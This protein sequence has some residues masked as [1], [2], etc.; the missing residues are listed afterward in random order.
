MRLCNCCRNVYVVFV[1]FTLGQNFVTCDI[2]AVET[3]MR[4]CVHVCIHVF[5]FMSLCMCMCTRLSVKTLWKCVN[6]CVHTYIHTYI[7]TY[8]RGLQ[9]VTGIK[10]F[11]KDP[12]E[13]AAA[14]EKP[15]SN[16]NYQVCACSHYVAT[17]GCVY[18][19]ICAH[20]C[21]T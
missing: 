7:H 11:S 19:Y 10:I 9:R 21:A 2:Q 4:R 13:L 15:I 17:L 6:V 20:A 18:T 16:T 3:E 12:R 1:Y 8:T 14:Q 5:V